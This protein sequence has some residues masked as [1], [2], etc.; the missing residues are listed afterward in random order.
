MDRPVYC[1]HCLH[2]ITGDP[3]TCPYCGKKIRERRVAH[4]KRGGRRRR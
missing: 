4:R 1:P 3:M 2:K